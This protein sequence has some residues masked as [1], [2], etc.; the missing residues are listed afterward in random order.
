MTAERT[1]RNQARALANAF[2]LLLKRPDH[3]HFVRG[4]LRAITREA[5]GVGAVFW[6]LFPGNR[7][8]R[9]NSFYQDAESQKHSDSAASDHARAL[10]ALAEWHWKLLE[11]HRCTVILRAR[12]PRTPRA[13]RQLYRKSKVRSILVFP[14]LMGNNLLGWITFITTREPGQI[15]PEKVAFMEATAQQAGMSIYLHLLH[16]R[17]REAVRAK[18]SARRARSSE[19]EM[20]QVGRLMQGPLAALDR[21]DLLDAF[22]E[23]ALR[24]M[25]G[26]LH[27]KGGAIWQWDDS[28]GIFVPT[29]TT[30]D[31]HCGPVPCEEGRRMGCVAQNQH[32]AQVRAWSRADRIQ[33]RRASMARSRRFLEEVGGWNEGPGSVLVSVP[34]SCHGAAKSGFVLITTDHAMQGM[35]ERLLAVQALALQ[36]RLAIRFAA[37]SATERRRA[38]A[39]ERSSLARD[40][41]DLLAQSFS[42]ILL[43]IE[44]M[45]AE[46]PAIPRLVE[47]RL[48]KI[49]AQALRSV[50]E[51]R[52]SILMLRPALLDNA[53]L[54]TA[55]R[56][57]ADEAGVLGG[58]P[59][60]VVTSLSGLVLDP[61][62]EMNLFAI[63]SE[64]IQNSVRH[65][66]ARQIVVELTVARRTLSLSVID[67][68]AGGARPR[69]S[70]P[71]RRHFGIENMR[72]RAKAVGGR[73]F[74][75]S[76]KGRG[77]RVRVSIPIS[78]S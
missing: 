31:G 48:E 66:A 77:T 74:W 59:I 47:D 72:S 6:R 67:D 64:A 65:A 50:E 57:L 24:A 52:R 3:P 18:E 19:E 2:G 56:A 17:E 43:Q 25:V 38:I 7:P 36:A 40:L 73:F 5:D 78:V 32:A 58:V 68:G 39:D 10:A 34:L 12:D 37:L 75:T 33:V 16:E 15:P 26:L 55:L 62:I 45:R 1:A 49:Q 70:G 27:G 8:H 42:G 29:W 41:H 22:F 4:I 54:A 20:Q 23:E 69:G 71:G 21:V 51:V 28:F 63:A 9:E 35:E 30:R 14:L 53:S 11:E 76:G 60:R 44:A 61:R 46:C 13:I